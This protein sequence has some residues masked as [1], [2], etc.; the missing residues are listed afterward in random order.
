MS[1]AMKKYQTKAKISVLDRHIVKS[2]NIILTRNAVG[3][4]WLTPIFTRNDRVGR[5]GKKVIFCILDRAGVRVIKSF[6]AEKFRK[7][8]GFEV[9]GYGEAVEWLCCGLY[10][11][12]F[13]VENKKAECTWVYPMRFSWGK[14][15]KNDFRREIAL[16]DLIK[17]LKRE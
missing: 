6:S 15:R 7:I 16:G 3:S 9:S 10:P 8:K 13:I 12:R 5:D 14:G 17:K 4:H 1:T 2:D 11:N